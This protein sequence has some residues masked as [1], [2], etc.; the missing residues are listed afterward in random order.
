MTYCQ[1]PLSV[2]PL[3]VLVDCRGMR[4]RLCGLPI[5]DD[6]YRL[7]QIAPADLMLMP[8]VLLAAAAGDDPDGGCRGADAEQRPAE[9]DDR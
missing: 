2:R 7:W 1:C 8:E 3:A 4:C 6:S 5:T 9:Q